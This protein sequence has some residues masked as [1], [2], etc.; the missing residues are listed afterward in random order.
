MA[1]TDASNIIAETTHL[2]AGI[3]V[4]YDDEALHLVYDMTR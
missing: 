1:L 3:L 2:V 4:L